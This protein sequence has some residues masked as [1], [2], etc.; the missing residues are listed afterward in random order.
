MIPADLPAVSAIAAR[1]HPDYPEDDAVFAERLRLWPD[2]CFVA[3]EEG[4]IL[5]Y[6]LTH[7]WRDGPPPLNSLLGALPE[8]P[9]S[10]YVHDVALLP[11]ARRRGLG[12][13]LMPLL[14]A[15]AGALGLPL[16]LVAIYDAEAYWR[17]HGFVAAGPAH[18]IGPGA[19]LM[20]RAQ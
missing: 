5:G 10:Y 6:A 7:P 3:E 16:V 1:V 14:A 20:R 18:A 19:V 12:D 8:R 9:R 15:R 2:G 13:A 4:A 17:R 11:T